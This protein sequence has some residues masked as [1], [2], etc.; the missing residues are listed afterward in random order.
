VA[1]LFRFNAQG[2][3]SAV[4]GKPAQQN[5]EFSVIRKVIPAQAGQLLPFHQDVSAFATLLVNM[6]VPL[7]KVGGDHPS[8]QFVRQRISMAEQTELREGEYNQ[9]EINEAYVHGRYGDRLWTVEE[10]HPGDCVIFLGT[11]IHRS[12]CDD[13]ARSTR[14]S[15]EIR[16]S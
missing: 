10:A 13:A 1:T 12:Y 11:T 6:W 14:C 2:L 16:W 9:I 3:A 5:V 15:A 8:I 4:L 7:T